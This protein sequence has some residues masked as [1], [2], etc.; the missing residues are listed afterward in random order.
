MAWT[1]VQNNGTFVASAG[2]TLALAF[3]SNVTVGNRIIV[4]GVFLGASGTTAFSATDNLGNTYTAIPASLSLNATAGFRTQILHAPV[5][6]G[7]ACTVT[8]TSSTSTNERVICISEISGLSG[9]LGTTP[10]NGTGNT[11]NPTINMTVDAADS[12]LVGALATGLSATQGT[13]WTL[14][15][16]PDGNAGEYRLPAGTGVQTVSFTQGS[17]AQYAISGA[18]FR[19]SGAAAPT[20]R[21]NPTPRTAV[22]RSVR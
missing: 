8:L 17:A 6:T 3:G 5:T 16:A 9:T 7:G 13:G 12:L 22:F 1:A 2:S 10:V 21:R 14:V 19:T 20:V 4:C 11:S 15:A 18:E